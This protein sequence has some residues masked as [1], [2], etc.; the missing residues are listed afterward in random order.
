MSDSYFALIDS[1]PQWG[2][3]LAIGERVLVVLDGKAYQVV[4]QD[5]GE[6]IEI[7]TPTAQATVL[8]Q[9]T[10]APERTPT[11]TPAPIADRPS[12]SQPSLCGGALAATLISAI[13]AALFAARR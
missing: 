9:R 11:A 3:Y 6:E 1:H 4:A 5:Q 13:G 12:R 10:P 7:P 2:A 8:S